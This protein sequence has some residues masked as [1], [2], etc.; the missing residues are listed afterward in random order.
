MAAGPVVRE[1]TISASGATLEG[2]ATIT[3]PAS[4]AKIVG[5]MVKYAPPEF[6]LT[7]VTL[8]NTAA[9]AGTIKYNCA[10][11]SGSTYNA[12]LTVTDSDTD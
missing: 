2:S 12:V 6:S 4:G 1:V 9:T 5:V 11:K 7:G 8:S 10:G 3:A